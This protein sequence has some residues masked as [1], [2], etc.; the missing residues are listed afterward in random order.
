M[1]WNASKISLFS[2]GKQNTCTAFTRTCASIHIDGTIHIGFT[3][4]IV[5][6]VVL[7]YNRATT[8][9]SR[10]DNVIIPIIKQIKMVWKLFRVYCVHR[11]QASFWRLTKASRPLEIVT[12]SWPLAQHIRHIK[13]DC[14]HDF[15]L[16]FRYTIWIPVGPISPHLFQ[17]QYKFYLYVSI[18]FH[19]TNETI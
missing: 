13:G 18:F 2:F 10:C 12:S 17:S 9:R 15:F 7:G 11:A 5:I 16:P 6:F 3:L 4:T 14:Y 19:R 1:R 8:Y